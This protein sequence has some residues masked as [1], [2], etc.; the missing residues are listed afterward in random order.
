M[1]KQATKQIV[2][3]EP[4]VITNMHVQARE[5]TDQHGR[6]V[7]G[8]RGWSRLTVFQKLYIA[9]PPAKANPKLVDQKRCT[10]KK[11]TDIEIDR[12]LDRRDAGK[13]FVKAWDFSV[14]GTKDSLDLSPGCAAEAADGMTIDRMAAKD[15]LESW[16]RHMGP[17]DWMIIR[18]VCGEN[19]DVAPVIA[20]ISPSYRDSSLARFREALDSLVV[21][22]REAHKER[23]RK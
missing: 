8:A 21:A 22:Q 4:A 13:E 3:D 23:R 6:Q 17:N 18:R 12:A 1:S 11:T 20:D 5:I 2:I 9:K 14:R 10:D 19:C 16:R 15:K 7:L